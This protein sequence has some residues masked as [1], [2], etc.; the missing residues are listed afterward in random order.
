[1]WKYFK[2]KFHNLSDAQKKFI[3]DTADAYRWTYNWGLELCN[4]RK[5][6]GELNP[7]WYEMSMEWTKVKNSGKYPWLKDYDSAT[8]KNALKDLKFGFNQHF[9]NKKL[10]H[11]PKFKSKKR[12][13]VSFH[14]R[15]GR[16][17]F[18]E[19]GYV[20]IPGFSQLRTDKDVLFYVGPNEVPLDCKYYNTRVSFDGIDYW[21]TL[22]IYE[23]DNEPEFKEE[24][25]T[26]VGIDVGK[27]ATAV[28]SD[29]TEF[30]L[31]QSK[32]DRV[33]IRK[34]NLHKAI[35][36]DVRKRRKIAKSTRTKYSNIPESNNQKKRQKKYLKMTHKIHN[37]WNTHYH[38][39]SKAI[40]EMD[41][42][43]VV[44]ETLH[45][46]NIKKNHYMAK[47]VSSISLP[48]IVHHIEYKCQNNGI[49]VIKADDGFL[50][51]QICSNCGS[52]RDIKRARTYRCKNCGLVIDRDLNAALNLRNHG[53]ERLSSL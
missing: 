22:S 1:M 28:L 32:L 4:K 35:M 42:D 11:Y 48:S 44:L 19:G 45:M 50:S 23:D 46:K 37:T 47:S 2:L 15:E 31:D 13:K 5:S 49:H 17:H 20:R 33:E 7:S 16:V 41:I 27:H 3:H 10:Y 53:L 12:S 24:I 30:V 29:G 18:Y 43:C 14:T 51:S 25:N 39:I 34:K 52:I 40:S 8:C 21:F 36:R 9:K 6:A 38:Q 26:V